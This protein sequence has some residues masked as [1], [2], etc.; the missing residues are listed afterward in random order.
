MS[1]TQHQ[2]EF[3]TLLGWTQP[4]WSAVRQWAQRVGKPLPAP[5]AWD[6][7]LNLPTGASIVPWM[8]LKAEWEAAFP[9]RREP[10]LMVE[11]VGFGA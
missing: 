4:Q 7:R 8:R 6:D 2:M 10:S 11:I 5:V 9:W 3:E 1:Q